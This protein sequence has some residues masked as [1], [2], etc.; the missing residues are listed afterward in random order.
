MATSNSSNTVNIQKLF[1]SLIALGYKYNLLPPA[2]CLNLNNLLLCTTSINEMFEKNEELIAARNYIMDLWFPAVNATSRGRTCAFDLDLEIDGLL[3]EVGYPINEDESS[4]T[5][6]PSDSDGENK[7][8]YIVTIANND[9][10]SDSDVNC[11]G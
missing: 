9:S 6:I 11:T 1:D 4:D 5:E 3:E 2:W 8:P 10:E 7:D